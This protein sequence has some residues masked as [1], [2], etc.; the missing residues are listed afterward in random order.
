MDDAANGKVRPVGLWWVAGHTKS[1]PPAAVDRRAPPRR[2]T[3]RPRSPTIIRTSPQ[4]ACPWVRQLGVQRSKCQ[5]YISPQVC[6]RKQRRMRLWTHMHWQVQERLQ[7]ATICGLSESCGAS[8]ECS[9]S[10]LPDLACS[11]CIPA[12]CDRTEAPGAMRS[13]PPS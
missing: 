4:A 11:C 8:S 1:T 2:C 9:C 5:C 12:K 13:L 3:H 6:P 10:R 7:T